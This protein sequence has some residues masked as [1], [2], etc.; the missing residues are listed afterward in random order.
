MIPDGCLLVSGDSKDDGL[1]MR[2][3]LYSSIY[4]PIVATALRFVGGL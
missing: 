1:P 4:F 2:P 3:S